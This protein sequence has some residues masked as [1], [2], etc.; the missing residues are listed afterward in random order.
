[1]LTF[2]YVP[3]DKLPVLHVSPTNLNFG[4]VFSPIKAKQSIL[5]ATKAHGSL[6]HEN[7]CSFGAV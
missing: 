5:Q 1:M 7:L 6:Q 3:M 4:L 2:S